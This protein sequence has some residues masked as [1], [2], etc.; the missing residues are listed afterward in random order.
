MQEAAA[1]AARVQQ[2]EAAI[3]AAEAELALVE[4][5]RRALDRRLAQRR[6]P[7][8][9]LTGALQAMGNR[10]LALSALQPGSLT[11][12]VHTRAVLASA[13][14]VVRQRTASLRSDLK[15]A[16]TLEAERRTALA[17]RREAE[18]RLEARRRDMLALAEKERIVARQAVGGARREAE[19]AVEL[20]EEARDLDAL[21]ARMEQS[22]ALRERLAALDGP[23]VRPANPQAA[24][25]P[26]RSAA[27]GAVTSPTSFILPVAG[28]VA[29]G[30]G[31]TG[32]AGG[33]ASGIALVPRPGAQV[34]APAGGRIVF[35]GA[36]EGYG[37]IVIIEHEGDWTSLVTGMARISVDVGQQVTSGS[38][39]GLAKQN[40]PR[41][42]YELRRGGNPVNPL[43]F[44]P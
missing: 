29:E 15:R 4:E 30:F 25:A 8:A 41:I 10:P 28:R 31:E 37:N 32:S 39:L 23:I 14:P 17:Q 7:L 13:V 19:L 6:E 1:L 12:V 42:S 26:S 5:Q 11:D 43:D 24:A 2:A 16:R 44:L 40:R 22:G 36:Y 21:V 27:S 33:R 20:A 34:V 38:P 3:E 18:S 9:R 35:A